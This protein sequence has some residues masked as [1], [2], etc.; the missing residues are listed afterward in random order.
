MMLEKAIQIA[1][2]GH[3][4]QTDKAGQPYLLHLFRVMLSGKTEEEQICGVL[5]DIVEDTEYTFEDLKNEGF[6]DEVVNALKCVTKTPN[7]DYNDFIG[8]ISKN[9]LAIKV[10]LNDLK[11]NMDLSRLTEITEKDK[12]RLMKY[13]NAR[14]KLLKCLN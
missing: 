9:P 7:E 13:Q 14:D 11:D 10:K 1:V 12:Q 8:R 2:N 3:K 4:G 5:H 6:S